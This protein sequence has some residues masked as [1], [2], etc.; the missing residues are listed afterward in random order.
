VSGGE[1]FFP[2]GEESRGMN[3]PVRT[4]KQPIRSPSRRALR[5]GCGTAGFFHEEAPRIRATQASGQALG[6][7]SLKTGLYI[8]KSLLILSTRALLSSSG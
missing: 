7:A 8:R 1:R 4:P 2:S 6:A 3:L 5:T